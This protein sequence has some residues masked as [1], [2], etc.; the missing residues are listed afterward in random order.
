[1]K[2][3]AGLGAME[4][5]PRLAA[6][7]A[8]EVFAGFVPMRWLE[9]YTNVTPMN[10]REVLLQNLQID[11]MDDMALLAEMSDDFNIPVALTFNS[12]CYMPEQ[13]PILGDLLAELHQLGFRS[14]ILADVGLMLW[15]REHGVP[16]DIHLSGEAG[17]FGPDALRF[18]HRFG[19]RRCIFPRKISPEEMA[20]C[21]QDFPDLEYEAF[22]LNEMCHFSGAYCS[23]LHCDCLDHMCN[24][25][26]RLV[27]KDEPPIP[28]AADYP[29]D[30]F[31]SGGCGLCALQRLQH[32]GVTHLKVVGR[33]NHIEWMER[34]VRLLR[35]ILDEGNL[36]PEFLRAKWLDNACSGRCYYPE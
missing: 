20:A 16:G 19:I 10:R 8:D 5:L 7:G 36:S 27:G 24:V 9:K 1:M 6:A 25:P 31:G 26:Y 17:C 30:G 32:A 3:T 15:L 21:I 34:D 33:G 35:Q 11:S 4:N 23:S 28:P 18:F 12:I 13:Y 22:I 29:A 14:W 2:I